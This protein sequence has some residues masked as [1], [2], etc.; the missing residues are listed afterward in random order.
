MKNL[1]PKA[2]RL[3]IPAL[4]NTR[5][6][7]YL[8]IHST[9]LT[10]DFILSL[11]SQLSRNESI[12]G[13]EFERDTI[14]DDGLIAL[15]HSLKNDT[16]VSQLS[17]S[18]NTSITSVSVEPLKELILTMTTLIALLID[19]INIDTNGALSLTETLKTNK[20][21]SIWLPRQHEKACSSL[22]Y[23]DTIKKRLHFI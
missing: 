3:L 15:V 7:E 1:S 8:R 5:N 12:W 13:L 20:K 21:I 2:A 9:P 11:S 19:G 14:D 6:V 17:V 22:P 23:Y 18:Y 10:S 16:R 4:L